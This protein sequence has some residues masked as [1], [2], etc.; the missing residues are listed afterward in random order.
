MKQEVLKNFDLPWL[1]V[2]GLILFVL[3]FSIYSWWTFRKKNHEMYRA[4]A[5]IPLEEEKKGLSL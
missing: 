2:S 4:A 3:C 1:P 5:L